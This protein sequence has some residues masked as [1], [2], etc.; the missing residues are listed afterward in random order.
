MMYDADVFTRETY[1]ALK[2]V[3]ESGIMVDSSAYFSKPVIDA[4]YKAVWLR[5]ST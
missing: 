4:I 3:N 2:E 1:D 5:D